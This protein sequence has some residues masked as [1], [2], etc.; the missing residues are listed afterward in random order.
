MDRQ[1]IAE[2]LIQLHKSNSQIEQYVDVLNEPV[3]I[4]TSE[5]QGEHII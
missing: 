1:Q 4:D 2:R 5:M 3:S